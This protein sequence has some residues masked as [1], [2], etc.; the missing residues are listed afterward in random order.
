MTDPRWFT[1]WRDPDEPQ[2]LRLRSAAQTVQAVALTLQESLFALYVHVGLYDSESRLSDVGREQP[3]S[4]IEEELSRK[5]TA[6]LVVFA[7]TGFVGDA[8]S[9]TS[10]GA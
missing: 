8:V 6:N 1:R 9:Q 2:E 3:G 7:Y 5:V 10:L 4:T